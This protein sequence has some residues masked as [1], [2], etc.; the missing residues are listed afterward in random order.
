MATTAFD[1]VIKEIEDTRDSLARALVDGTA[2][3]YA[4]YRLALIHI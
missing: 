4:E 3:D 1:V 2:R